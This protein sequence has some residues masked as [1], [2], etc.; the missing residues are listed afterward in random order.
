MNIAMKSFR[1]QLADMG[2]LRGRSRI[3][4]E[5]NAAIE[6]GDLANALVFFNELEINGNASHPDYLSY[7]RVLAGEWQKQSGEE[8]LFIAEP[9]KIG[10]LAALKNSRINDRCFILCTGPSL[11]EQNLQPLEN[12]FTIGLNLL[13]KGDKNLGFSPSILVIE[14][15]NILI[16]CRKEIGRLKNRVLFLPSYAKNIFPPK[17]AFY[18][19]NWIKDDKSNHDF[20]FFSTDASRRI[21][22]SGS[23]AYMALQIAFYLGFAKVYFLGLD[24]EYI[25][26]PSAR[27]DRGEI[28]YTE[29][30]PNHYPPASFE[31]GRIWTEPDPVAQLTAFEKAAYVFERNG[32]EIINCSARSKLDLLPR[33]ELV[34]VLSHKPFVAPGSGPFSR[35]EMTIIIPFQNNE[36]SL[37]DCLRSVCAQRGN[38]EILLVN[39]ASGDSS[40]QIAKKWEQA[41]PRVRI[42][43]KSQKNTEA[44]KNSAME[45]AR[46]PYALFINPGDSLEQD[47]IEKCIA[48]I[49]QGKPDIFHFGEKSKK[50]KH[51][52]ES[53]FNYALFPGIGALDK[54]VYDPF[55]NF[56]ASIYK[57]AF[58][59]ENKLVFPE[60]G[61][62]PDLLFNM[63][64]CYKAAHMDALPLASYIIGENCPSLNA[65]IKAIHCDA[66]NFKE[67]MTR[68]G[69][70]ESHPY[71]FKLFLYRLIMQNHERNGQLYETGR[72]EN[73][74]ELVSI[75]DLDWPDNL[76]ILE[77][78]FPG[79]SAKISHML[80]AFA[81]Q[82]AK[83]NRKDDLREAGTNEHD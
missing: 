37:D 25:T 35:P 47:I 75:Y 29:K 77:D 21:W 69:L 31:T 6:A 72:G 83:I 40:P 27:I 5:L 36:N 57:L 22:S 55:A 78:R 81:Q 16:N 63:A 43:H 30:D 74:E 50:N 80:R 49:H 39:A 1:G 60:N 56:R 71:L 15:S 70:D 52:N 3:L 82:K 18:Y 9:E 7:E 42:V 44:A 4:Q 53:S 20:P 48:K 41:D 38:I 45:Q 24:F 32:R 11:E 19:L 58:L 34:E 33:M 14:D 68:E 10:Q 79:E 67:F 66:K 2:P 8:F 59:K 12:E 73:P 26:P 46:A 51:R 23:A 54:K 76:A 64:A 65:D 62:N 17:P 61:A 13:Y 28:I